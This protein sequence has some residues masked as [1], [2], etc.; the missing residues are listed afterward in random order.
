M[1]SYFLFICNSSINNMKLLAHSIKSVSIS[2][3]VFEIM[4]ISFFSKLVLFL[5]I[6]CISELSIKNNILKKLINKANKAK[7]V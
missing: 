7:R 2:M 4:Q 1:P 6:Y 5:A 3:S